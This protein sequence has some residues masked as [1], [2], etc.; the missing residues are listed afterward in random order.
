[1]VSNTSAND[2]HDIVMNNRG[3]ESNR[4]IA[5]LDNEAE[6]LQAQV[7]KLQAR[8]KDMEQ[9]TGRDRH[10]SEAEDDPVK[11]KDIGPR[12]RVGGEGTNVVEPV[13]REGDEEGA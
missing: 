7:F 9:A 5:N 6:M 10:L 12:D 11:I 4:L 13:G 8:L 3:P 2:G 1:M